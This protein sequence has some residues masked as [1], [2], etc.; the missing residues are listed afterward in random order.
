MLI[1]RILKSNTLYL[2]S[3]FPNKVGHWQNVVGIVSPILMEDYL[4]KQKHWKGL[5]TCR[6]YRRP[7]NINSKP[8]SVWYVLHQ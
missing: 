5:C 3:G 1:S 7:K 4:N 8:Y 2:S 6:S